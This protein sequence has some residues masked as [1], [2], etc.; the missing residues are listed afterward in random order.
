MDNEIVIVGENMMVGLKWTMLS[1]SKNIVME[2]MSPS[3]HPI[4]V[5]NI[6]YLLNGKLGCPENK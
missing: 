1:N 5:N 4:V 6:M 2:W 3:F